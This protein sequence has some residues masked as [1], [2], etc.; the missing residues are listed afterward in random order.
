MK[1]S[2][3]F[4]VAVASAAVLGSVVAVSGT[5]NAAFDPDTADRVTT[6]DQLGVEGDTYPTTG[7]FLGDVAAPAGTVTFDGAGLN[8]AGGNVQVLNAY[9]APAS[10]LTDLVLDADFVSLGDATFQ[11]PM[12]VNDTGT[13]TQFTTL[14]P[15]ATGDA[16]FTADSAWITSQ[17][18][19]TYVAGAQATLAEFQ[20]SIDAIDADGDQAADATVLAYGFI[21]PS[22][23]TSSVQ[24]V[25]F[26]DESTWFIPAPTGT[27]QPA[28]LTVTQART[29]GITVDGGGFFPNEAL[30]VYF[31]VENAASASPLDVTLTA[32]AQGRV[33]GTVVIPADAVPAAGTY[34]IT[35]GGLES[36]VTLQGTVTVLADGAVV[37]PVPAGPTAPV[38]VPVRANAAFTG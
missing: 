36:G 23:L 30:E 25:A 13:G 16:G 7:W 38:A 31:A 20:A 24:A 5:A 1:Q 12:F 10:T 2:R 22:P 32:D 33:Q 28:T 29:T 26:G 21:T 3:I 34:F 4:S 14:R 17:A 15:V 27:Y 19:G 9:D 8:S 11:V 6:N 18:F 37:T 35:I